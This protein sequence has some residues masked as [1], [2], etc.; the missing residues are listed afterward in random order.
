[1]RLHG[2]SRCLVLLLALGALLATPAGATGRPATGSKASLTVV[3]SGLDNPRGLAV[4]RG[5]TVLVA[6]AGRGGPGPC[7]EGPEGLACLGSSGAITAIRHGRQRRVVTGLPSAALADGSNATGPHDVGVGFHGKLLVTV[8]LG[9]DPARRAEFGPGGAKLGRLLRVTSHGRVRTVADL[10]AFEAANDPDQGLPGTLPDSNPFGMLLEGSK[11]TVADAGGNDV[12][13]VDRHG[14]IKVLAVFEP[15][16]VQAPGIPDPIPM[17]PVPTSVARGPD[18]ALYVGQLIGFPFPVGGANVWRLAP[19]RAPEVV[20]DGFTNIIDI[21]F[22]R[23][24]RLL[25][26]EIAH[27]GL[28]SGDPTGAL[29]RVERDGSRTTLASEGLVAPGGMAVGRHGVIYVSNKTT[30]AGEG[31]VLRIRT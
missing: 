27:N 6:E 9:L 21:A 7:V 11:A 3:A 8:G 26:L 15:E 16:F 24:G 2:R 4:T 17:Q 30:S 23:R 12:L 19:G 25:V 5:G 10:A 14:R 20:A 1:M 13:R 18:G 31:E 28:L 22:D 29:I